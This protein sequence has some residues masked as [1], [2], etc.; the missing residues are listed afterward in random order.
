[1]H[2]GPTHGTCQSVHTH[3][4]TLIITPITAH[5]N[6]PPAVA[7][8]VLVP[9]SMSVRSVTYP[10]PLLNFEHSTN[11]RPYRLSRAARTSIECAV[12]YDKCRA[13]T[14]KQTVYTLTSS[15]SSSSHPHTPTHTVSYSRVCCDTAAWRGISTVHLERLEC[16]EHTDTIGCAHTPGSIFRTRSDGMLRA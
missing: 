5:S 13:L 6:L 7:S 12:A 8:N 4:N 3:H 2:P 15:S 1:V 10:P 16:R 9:V 11:R 14:R